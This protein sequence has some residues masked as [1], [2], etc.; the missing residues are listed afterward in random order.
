MDVF[1]WE[2]V[3]GDD[4]DKLIEFLKRNFN[5]S[6][7]DRAEIKKEAHDDVITISD[8]D[9]ELKIKLD[10]SKSKAM[11][12]I[13]DNDLYEFDVKTNPQNNN[14]NEVKSFS[15]KVGDVLIL[16][17]ILSPETGSLPDPKHRHAIRLTS[18]RTAVDVLNDIKVLEITWGQEDALPFALCLEKNGKPISIAHGNIVLA[19]HG[20][21]IN[22]EKI[23]TIIVGGRYYPKLSRKPLTQR[24]PDFEILLWISI[25]LLSSAFNYDIQNIKPDIYLEKNNDLKRWYPQRDLLVSDEFAQE[26]VVEI[27]TDDTAYIRFSNMNSRDWA[28]QMMMT[29]TTTI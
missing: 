22:A 25:S 13:G 2:K 26:F 4:T 8:H 10:N 17:E 28:E 11:L 16:E 19:D 29:T 27:E 24:G 7:I 15:L 23:E 18:V 1:I 3:P 9:N 20:Y 6:W 14:L 12:S 21:T 5:L